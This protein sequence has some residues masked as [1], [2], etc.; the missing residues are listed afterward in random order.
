MGRLLRS[1]VTVSSPTS[2]IQLSRLSQVIS[3]RA[4]IFRYRLPIL[5]LSQ[6][7][8]APVRSLSPSPHLQHPSEK[9]PRCIRARL[10]HVRAKGPFAGLRAVLAR[11]DPVCAGFG[12]ASIRGED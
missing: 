9:V 12:I 4:Y 5:T 3:F 10:Y 2:A 8:N 11:M 1:N 6:H 7:Q